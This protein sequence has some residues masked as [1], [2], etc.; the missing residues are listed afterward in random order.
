MSYLTPHEIV[1]KR[2]QLKMTQV[3]LARLIHVSPNT[4]SRFERGVHKSHHIVVA[5]SYVLGCIERNEP[6]SGSRLRGLV[7][8]RIS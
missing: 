7:L 8:G 6:I 3:R 1:E 4:I 5:A 2:K